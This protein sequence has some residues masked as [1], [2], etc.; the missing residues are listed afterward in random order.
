MVTP[1]TI[2]SR[3]AL[4]VL[5]TAI[6]SNLLGNTLLLCFMCITT[7]RTIFTPTWMITPLVP[8]QIPIPSR[9]HNPPKHKLSSPRPHHPLT[10]NL[11]FTTRHT[12]WNTSV[13]PTFRH[14]SFQLPTTPM[15]LSLS[16]PSLRTS[17]LTTPLTSTTFP[18][19]QRQFT[20]PINSMTS[21]PLNQANHLGR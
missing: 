14:K 4:H 5:H 13:P 15:I 18:L 9:Y 19:S 21:S 11:P 20:R 16:T 6:L 8:A 12:S 7:P 10:S 3:R 1:L 2:Y 17:L